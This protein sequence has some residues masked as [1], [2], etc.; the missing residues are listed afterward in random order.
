MNTNTLTHGLRIIS[1]SKNITGDIWEAHFG[2]AAIAAY[3]FIKEN[4]LFSHTANRIQFQVEKMLD[5]KSFANRS[6]PT[7]KIHREQAETLILES[8]SSVI[9]ELHWVGHNVIY[10]ALSLQAIRELNGWGTESEI[11]GICVLI[12]SFKRTI[13]GRSWL[14]YTASEVKRLTIDE[15]D[16]FPVI[17]NAQQLSLL[18]LNEL[19]SFR[20]IY[21]AEAH[22]DLIGHMLTFSHA[23]NILF[24]LGYISY[25]ERGIPPLLKLIK[26]LRCTRDL[27]PE[28]DIKLNSP[29][30]HLPLVQA[31]RSEWLPLEKEY[32]CVDYMHHDWDFGH[33]F[34]FP[35]SFYNHLNRA[36]VVMTD[37]VENFRYII[38]SQPD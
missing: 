31:T 32:W 26:V 14:G 21:K 19:A 13:P 1:Y 35:Y 28:A 5:A 22:H 24:D 37:A 29:V 18:V 11:Q 38:C 3:F 20:A 34:K 27:E 15:S 7:S 9:D 12:K 25:F 10:A 23:L 30:D 8:L 36:G 2:V 16:E 4:N 6:Y 17:R 33:V